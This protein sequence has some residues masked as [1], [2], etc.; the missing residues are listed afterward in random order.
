MDKLKLGIPKGSMQ[1][2]TINLFKKAGYTITANS[3]SYYPQV[4]DDQIDVMLL[5]P[6]E[7]ALYVEQG[8][9][10]VGLAGRD[11]VVECGTDVKE[12]AELVYSKATNQPAR[13]V[14]AVAQDSKITSVKDLEG[15]VIFTE[16]IDTTKQYL[17]KNNVNAIVKFSHGATEVK[18]PHL[19]EAIV[20]ITETGSSLRANG[21][22]VIDTVMESVTIIIANQK[23]WKNQWKRTKIENLRML[24]SGALKAESK[25]GL[26]MNVAEENL[27]PILDI[28]PAMR[29]PTISSLSQDG[30]YAIETIIDQHIVRELIPQLRR[31]GA[32]GI[33]EYPLNKVIP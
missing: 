4:D 9:I 16:L 14:L 17:E 6:Q 19:C 13:W 27:K 31:V 24:L 12:I 11:W 25:V 8:V 1:D 21:L 26:K 18:I 28:L 10:D 23:T 7:M 5:R 29:N 22:K 30:W 32:E 15:K 3:R 33:I 20:E 2:S